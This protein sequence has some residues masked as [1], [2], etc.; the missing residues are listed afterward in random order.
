[1][2]VTGYSHKSSSDTP[3]KRF[4]CVSVV[5]MESAG[6]YTASRW[7]AAQQRICT[8]KAELISTAF[9]AAVPLAKA[10]PFSYESCVTMGRFARSCR[11][12]ST[13]AVSLQSVVDHCRHAVH[14]QHVDPA[15]HDLLTAVAT[16]HHD[17]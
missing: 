5:K 2:F 13:T 3:S 15:A 4:A 17:F 16:A 6:T 11:I 12:L 14:P 9:H 8:M 7:R 10:S 1:M